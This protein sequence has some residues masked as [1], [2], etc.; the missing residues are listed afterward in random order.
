MYSVRGDEGVVG[1]LADVEESLLGM[2]EE[3]SKLLL[4]VAMWLGL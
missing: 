2:G 1:G 3:M 4:L